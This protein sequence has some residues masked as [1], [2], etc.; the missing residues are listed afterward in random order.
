M[1]RH[2][3][4]KEY[5]LKKVKIGNKSEKDRENALNEVRIL[6]SISHPNIIGYKEAFVD[7]AS[8]TLWYRPLNAASLWNMQT[9]G[10]SIKKSLSTRRK[11]PPFRKSKFGISPFRSLKVSRLFIKQMFFIEI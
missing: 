9:M 2:K 6:A 7:E 11:A 10:I 5:A 8:N 4:N 1:R 3:D